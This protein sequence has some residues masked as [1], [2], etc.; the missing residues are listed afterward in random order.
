MARRAV[1]RREPQV[2]ALPAWLGAARFWLAA[3]AV[4]LV[5]LWVLSSGSTTVPNA[6][7]IP[8]MDK[9]AHFGYFFGGG[10]L[11]SAALFGGNPRISK[12]RLVLMV[13][14]AAAVI[15]CLDEYHQTFTP[16]RSGND[17]WDWLAD[18]LGGTAGAFVF[19]RLRHRLPIPESRKNG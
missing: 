10:G 4:W 6:P 12:T 1:G 15:G 16:G 18:V 5:A 14:I 8:F 7:Q 13:A 9:V 19:L 17:P 11:L 3:Y 2:K